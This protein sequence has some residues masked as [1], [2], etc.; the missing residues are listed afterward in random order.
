MRFMG[1]HTMW[2]YS[3]PGKFF[4][5]MGGIPVHRGSADREAMRSPVTALG[6]GSPVVMFPEGLRRTGPVLADLFDGP[7]FVPWRTG[8]PLLPL[9]LGG[10]GAA[11][12]RGSQWIKPAKNNRRA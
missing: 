1:K 11:M 7:A 12:P 3:L 9:G 8:V 4:D 2:K 6:Y 10:S 5:A